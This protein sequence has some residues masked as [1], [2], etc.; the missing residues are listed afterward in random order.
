M[1]QGVRK[2]LRGQYVFLCLEYSS[3]QISKSIR[4]INSLGVPIYQ[5]R[6]FFQVSPQDVAQILGLVI[7]KFKPINPLF[8]N[9]GN[10]RTHI[11]SRSSEPRAMNWKRWSEVISSYNSTHSLCVWWCLG[12]KVFKNSNIIFSEINNK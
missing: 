8:L 3:L 5:V 7:D 12:T 11:S 1:K 6:Y 2:I 10:H 4:V 9:V